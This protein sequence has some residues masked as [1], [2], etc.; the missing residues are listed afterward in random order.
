MTATQ[1]LAPIDTV[2][3]RVRSAYGRWGR[4]TTVEQMRSDWDALFSGDA[5]EA[6]V[7]PVSAGGVDCEW[8]A[9]PG[10]RDDRVVVYFHGGGFRI[11]SVRS[12]RAL[13]AALSAASG[14]RVLGVEYRRAPEH[15]FPA[16]VDDGLAVYA[17][18]REQGIAAG[19]I[20][21]AGDSAGAG[22]ALSALLSLRDQAKSMP[23][24]AVLMSAWTDLSASGDSYRSRAE[25]DPIHQRPMILAMARGYLG[26]GVDARD[27]IA[28]P[29]FADLH[30]LPP[31]LLQVGDRE[32]VLDDSR[33]FAAKAKDAG[34]DVK[35]EVWDDMIHVFQQ[36]PAELVE[37]RRA[38]ASLGAF[39]RERLA[40]EPSERGFLP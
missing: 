32:T 37:A 39:L 29:L 38:V 28:S 16:P 22:L 24:A 31:L 4:T 27:P 19:R 8:I 35:L 7:Q 10:S 25:A 14:C 6:T 34:V 3:A 36:F 13:M 12:H 23:V 11:G 17:W 26:E 1:A 2:I 15:R 20:A 33:A 18:L 5:F 30:G 21:F 9:A 40:V